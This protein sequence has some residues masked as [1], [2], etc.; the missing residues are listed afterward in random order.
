EEPKSSPILASVL[1]ALQ[2]L[3]LSLNWQHLFMDIVEP[4]IRDH[5]QTVTGQDLHSLR[6]T[7]LKSLESR[8]LSRVVSVTQIALFVNAEDPE[9][10]LLATKLFDRLAAFAR[11]N[12][13]GGVS[14]ME[15]PRRNR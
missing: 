7:S 13:F 11:G 10:S 2:V 5:L 3:N 14:V 4:Q 9:I 6:H 12:I 1:R 8:V 15:I